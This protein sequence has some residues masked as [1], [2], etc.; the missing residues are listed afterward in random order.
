MTYVLSVEIPH[1]E[2]AHI[3]ILRRFESLGKACVAAENAYA[4]RL[5]VSIAVLQWLPER[6]LVDIFDGSWQSQPYDDDDSPAYE[7][8]EDA[9]AALCDV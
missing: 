1:E 3:Q 9:A 8:L 7:T 4:T 2:R 6:K 5:Y